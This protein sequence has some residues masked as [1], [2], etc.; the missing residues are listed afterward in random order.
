MLG[1][2]T[3]PRKFHRF[4]HAPSRA[5][6]SSVDEKHRLST[7][8]AAAYVTH[9]VAQKLVSVLVLY[10]SVGIVWQWTGKHFQ[11]ALYGYVVDSGTHPVVPRPAWAYPSC[12]DMGGG[13]V[14]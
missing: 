8:Q 4:P 13:R 1:V 9:P 3:D 12:A 7:R 5:V 11:Q 14:M 2:I 6:Y 10:V